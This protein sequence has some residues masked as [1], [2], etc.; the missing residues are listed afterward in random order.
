MTAHHIFALPA[1]LPHS[2]T[3]WYGIVRRE[4]GA[5]E[6]LRHVTPGICVC[7]WV[8]VYVS[9][10]HQMKRLFIRETVCKHLLLS[11][12]PCDPPHRRCSGVSL[13]QSCLLCT[14]CLEG[15]EAV[16]YMSLSRMDLSVY[17]ST[18]LHLSVDAVAPV[19][20]DISP[21]RSDT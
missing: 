13:V 4:S 18:R 8:L 11:A 1:A 5:G 3:R 6:A 12:L 16:F 10:C 17:M 7:L 21:F 14:C 20:A 15:L 9:E 2:S 19:F